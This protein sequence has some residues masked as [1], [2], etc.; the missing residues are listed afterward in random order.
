MGESLHAGFDATTVAQLRARGLEKWASY[1]EDILGAFVAEMDFGIAPPIQQRLREAV[2]GAQTGYLT[3]PMFRELNRATAEFLQRRHGWQVAASHVHTMPDVM[4]A[5]E[6]MLRFHFP[7]GGPVIVP[8]PCYMPF[9]RFLTELGHAP[10]QIPVVHD[11]TQFV[12]DY[13]AIDAAFANGAKALLLCNPHNPVGRVYSR[14]ELLRL[15]QVVEKHGARVFSDEIHAPLV[16]PGNAADTSRHVPYASVSDAAAAHAV[17][18]VSASKAWNLPGLKCAQIVFSNDADLRDFKRIE[19]HLTHGSTSTLGVFATVAAYDHGEPWLADVLDYLRGNRDF[20][21]T[22]LRERLPQI[23]FDPP[24]GTYLAWLD[25]SALGLP[26]P[27]GAWFRQRA[28]VALT[29]G[30]DCG[31]DFG[32]CVRLNAG[33]AATDS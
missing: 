22:F 31:D 1:P 33:H 2:D 4:K 7:Q 10:V 29:D 27:L 18:T 13:D 3:T 8:T 30:A 21:A 20:A 25:C 14:E 23:R 16:Y 24:Q 5:L 28:K 32:H 15:A 12:L 6:T 9:L 19:H 17:T 11:G 26:Q